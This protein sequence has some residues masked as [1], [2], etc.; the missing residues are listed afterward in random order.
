MFTVV[1]A[2]P[3]SF[4]YEEN[5]DAVNRFANSTE[6]KAY[7]F[8]LTNPNKATHELAGR[9]L[10]NK[11]HQWCTYSMMCLMDTLILSIIVLFS[12]HAT[13]FRGP[14][15][16]GNKISQ[17]MFFAWWRFMRW[18]VFL[19]LMLTLLGLIAGFAS[20]LYIYQLKAPDFGCIGVARKQCYNWKIGLNHPWGTF[21]NA[22]WIALLGFGCFGALLAGSAA[23]LFKRWKFETIRDREMIGCREHELFE[24]ISKACSGADGI[25]KD[26]IHLAVY[27]LM[28]DG[29]DIRSLEEE[30][31]Y[32]NWND[33]SD[34]PVRVKQRLKMKLSV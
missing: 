5:M 16:M 22:G 21:N 1:A 19:A 32:I 6:Y 30:F 25:E 29:Y 27:I 10:V 2:V 26:R 15:F 33:Y 23:T 31:S 20:L 34:F 13:S 8:D 4:S 18:L 14:S 17:E 7:N 11:M 3:M 12:L 24:Y 28:S 9:E